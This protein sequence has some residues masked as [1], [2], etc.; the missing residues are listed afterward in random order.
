MYT[1]NENE[2]RKSNP[3]ITE[4]YTL[5]ELMMGSLLLWWTEVY[6]HFYPEKNYGATAFENFSVWS[7]SI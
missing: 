5:L 6:G 4:M 2:I 7:R 3:D 1:E